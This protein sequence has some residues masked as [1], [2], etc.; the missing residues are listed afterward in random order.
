MAR[1]RKSKHSGRRKA[2]H[3]KVVT[4]NGKRRKMC[5]SKKGK[6]VSNKAAHHKRSRSR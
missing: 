5:W 2:A 3:C 1:A 6:L 4:V